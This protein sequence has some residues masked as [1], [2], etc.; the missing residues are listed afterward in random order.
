MGG[1]VRP[2]VPDVLLLYTEEATRLL[3]DAGFAF[4]I[5]ETKD[6]RS[7]SQSEAT[8]VIRM[9]ADEVSD[10]LELTVCVM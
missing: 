2:E 10:C 1:V 8:R 4:R 5:V 6:P 9:R 3:A 7:P